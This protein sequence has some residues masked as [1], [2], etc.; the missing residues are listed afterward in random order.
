MLGI[1]LCRITRSSMTSLFTHIIYDLV[2]FC[3]THT[4]YTAAAYLGDWISSFSHLNTRRRLTPDF[5]LSFNVVWARSKECEYLRRRK[6]RIEEFSSTLQNI[7]FFST[8]ISSPS[9]IFFECSHTRRGRQKL[10]RLSL[11]LKLIKF[12][13]ISFSHCCRCCWF[14]CCLWIGKMKREIQFHGNFPE[15][16]KC[17][18]LVNFGEMKFSF[19]A[20]WG[21]RSEL[22]VWGI[23]SI[24]RLHSSLAGQRTNCLQQTFRTLASA[25]RFG[26]FI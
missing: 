12:N 6:K 15:T 11:S 21:S 16:K 1:F 19:C 13:L 9:C 5:H 8:V 22:K 14:G 24:S 10:N 20:E 23:R 26:K 25:E 7:F 17:V 18:F 4:T 2:T 3:S